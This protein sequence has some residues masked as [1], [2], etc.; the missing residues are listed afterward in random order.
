M[1][2]HVR[3]FDCVYTPLYRLILNCKPHLEKFPPKKKKQ[4]KKTPKIAHPCQLVEFLSISTRGFTPQGAAHAIHVIP[5][6]T[7]HLFVSPPRLALEV[8][9]E[10]PGNIEYEESDGQECHVCQKDSERPLCW[11][12]WISAKAL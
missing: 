5:Y 11:T 8:W 6:R 12:P 1:Y 10:R 2:D 7:Y 3:F 9:F 4:E